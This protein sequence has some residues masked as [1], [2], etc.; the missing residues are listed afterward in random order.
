VNILCPIHEAEDDLRRYDDRQT[1]EMIFK[2][3][4]AVQVAGELLP[5]GIVRCRCA[6]VVLIN[7][8]S[9]IEQLSKGDDR[10]A[11][12]EF[13]F[14]PETDETAILEYLEWAEFGDDPSDCLVV[15]VP[16]PTSQPSEKR[17]LRIIR[18]FETRPLG[19]REGFS[20]R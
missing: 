8:D 14:A 9:I 12:V 1:R 5:L 11:Y 13:Q 6:D 17:R 20:C 19:W 2:F 3:P 10:P 7:R 15:N 16:S 18:R 4:D